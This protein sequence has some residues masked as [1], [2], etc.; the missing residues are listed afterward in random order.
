MYISGCGLYKGHFNKVTSL[1]VAVYINGCG[2]LILTGLRVVSCCIRLINF[3]LLYRN[4]WTQEM[5]N[6][7]NK[8]AVSMV[9]WIKDGSKICIVYE[10]G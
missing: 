4:S 10:D 1:R 8:S 3:L 5:I 9:H 2:L 6:N 7:R